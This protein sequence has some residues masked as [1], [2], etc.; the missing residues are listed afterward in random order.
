MS[1]QHSIV[2]HKTNYFFIPLEDDYLAMYECIAEEL[3]PI[4]EEQKFKLSGP[5]DC[6]AMIASV[7]EAWMNSKRP[8][9][10]CDEDLF[11]Y[12]TYDEWEQALRYRYK[13]STIIQC[14]KEMEVEGYWA[15]DSTPLIKEHQGTVKKRHF[16]QNTFEYQLN[17]PVVIGLL[18]QLPEQSPFDQKAKPSLGRPRKSSVKI[19]GLNK[20]G[21]NSDD[22][23]VKTDGQSVKTNDSRSK[24]NA[25]FYTQTRQIEQTNTDSA[26]SGTSENPQSAI[27]PHT[28]SLSQ[29]YVPDW[30][31]DAQREHIG[32]RLDGAIEK[33]LVA[34][35]ETSD[36]FTNS[37]DSTGR[38]SD[39]RRGNALPGVSGVGQQSANEGTTN[40]VSDRAGQSSRSAERD[41]RTPVDGKGEVNAPTS[42]SSPGSTHHAADH[43]SALGTDATGRA[44]TST[45][46]GLPT[47][48]PEAPSRAAHG[49]EVSGYRQVG[50]QATLTA[51]V[52]RAAARKEKK[53]EYR[54]F[55][56]T[57]GSAVR[58]WYEEAFGIKLDE[59]PALAVACNTL[60][61]RESV[62]RENML[63]VRSEIKTNKWAKANSICPSPQDLAN[64]TGVT[65]WEKWLLPA[66]NRRTTESSAGSDETVLWQGRTM[67]YAEADENG[68]QGG[69]G[70]FIQ[71]TQYGKQG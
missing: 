56:T 44:S 37:F 12:F 39:P 7:L 26:Y 59:T 60:G 69:F 40:P 2:P 23:D 65:R 61:K 15:D 5:S 24:I 19:N 29:D 55:F 20:N 35:G 71:H 18:A 22:R 1:R 49:A 57:Q 41:A 11:V 9:A 46:A 43:P 50:E 10:K 34:T 14:L 30:V 31:D 67:T 51:A 17:L 64:D 33:I 3:D 48:S 8:T 52:K 58:D 32:Q 27:A 62:T 42:S 21:L 47:V 6:K 36:G 53:T 70:D 4:K 16:V 13:R 54:I 66:M 45:Q 28:Q 38:D 25:P 63:L 68:W